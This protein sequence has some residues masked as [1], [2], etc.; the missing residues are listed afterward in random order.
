[1]KI[2]AYIFGGSFDPMHE[3]H[4]GIVRHLCAENRLVVI[5]VTE[6]NPFKARSFASHQLRVKMIKQILAAE[7]I[8][9]LERPGEK[10]VFLSEYPYERVADFVRNWR[11]SISGTIHWV[12]GEDIVDEVP[13]WRDW[14]TLDVALH[15]V[16]IS[17]LVHSTD[18]REGRVPPHSAIR[19]LTLAENIYPNARWNISL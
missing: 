18:V 16:P 17:L 13:K 10:G 1:M 15:A 11:K 7:G 19:E 4:V 14:E 9:L 3:G 12:V 2:D 5:A 8:P 6:Q